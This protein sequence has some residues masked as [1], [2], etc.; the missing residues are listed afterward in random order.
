M[1]GCASVGQD[2]GSA[3]FDCQDV[4]NN[5]RNRCLSWLDFSVARSPDRSRLTGSRHA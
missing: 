2:L 5:F 3:L 1:I 4:V